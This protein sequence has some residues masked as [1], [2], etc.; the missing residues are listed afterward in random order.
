MTD[1]NPA[2]RS[3]DTTTLSS[4]IDTIDD[5]LDATVELLDSAIDLC[6]RLDP[7]AL[8]LIDPAT[9]TVSDAATAATLAWITTELDDITTTVRAAHARMVAINARARLLR[10]RG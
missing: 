3:T 2:D 10:P 7:A 1:T 4:R 8:Q 9:G 6:R 5:G